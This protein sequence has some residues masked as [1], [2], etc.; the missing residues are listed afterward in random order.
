[1]KNLFKRIFRLIAILFILLNLVVIMHA[2][3]FTHFYEAGSVQAKPQS[4]KTGLDIA[5]EMLMGIK[6]MKQKPIAPDTAFERVQ[7]VTADSLRLSAWLFKVNSPKGTVAIFHGHGSEKS[8]SLAQSAVLNRLGF[9]TLLV[10]FRAHGESD[11]NT[12]TIGY[13]EAKDV[14]AAYTFLQGS[15]ERNIILYGISLGAATVAKAIDDYSL[16]PSKVILEMPFASLH[17]AV[18]GRIKMMGVPAQPLSAM[19]TFWGGAMHGFWAFNLKPYIYVKSI[20][21]PTLLQWGAKDN[22]VLRTEID[23]VY[24]NITAAKN[25][26]VYE[27]SGHQNLCKSEP[28]KWF[29]NISAFLQ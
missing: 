16:K 17:Q 14:Q 20:Q 7:I 12:C 6:A 25:L 28:D 24:A 4:E 27:Q 23:D 9:N 29:E 11:G 15:G 1:M 19:L 13:D 18:Q 22:R 10:D 26:V 2:Y 3:K 5:G 21:S 8:A